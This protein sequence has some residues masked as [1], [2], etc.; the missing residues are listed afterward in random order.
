MS[1]FFKRRNSPSKW[2][3]SVR[4]IFNIIYHYINSSWGL[5]SWLHEN[6]KFHWTTWDYPL[7]LSEC[8]IAWFVFFNKTLELGTCVVSF[9]RLIVYSVILSFLYFVLPLLV[10]CIFRVLWC[11][12]IAFWNT[13]FHFPIT[14][15]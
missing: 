3:T 4:C 15:L 12:S 7:W 6:F 10:F 2:Q 14:V 8:H 9:E 1:T 5:K 13:G 11:Y